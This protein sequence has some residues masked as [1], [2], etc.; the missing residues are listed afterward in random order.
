MSRAPLLSTPESWDVLTIYIFVSATTV[1]SVLVRPHEGAE[2]PVHYVSWIAR[3]GGSARHLR[4][5]F[6]THTIHVLTNQLLR[7]VLHKLEISGR[8]VKWAIKLGE[9]DIHYKPCPATKG[10]A[11]AD[12]ILEFTDPQG[13]TSTQV[14]TE[15]SVHSSQL[16]VANNGNLDL[17]QP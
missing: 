10:Q 11:V 16:H 12:F 13:S 14:I 8:L 17:T 4:P 9:F 2:H 1:S 6:Q 3:C 5:Y 15:P 7:Q